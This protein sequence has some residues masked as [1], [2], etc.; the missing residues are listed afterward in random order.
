ML[1][2]I[3]S[4]LLW[5]S[6]VAP[7]CARVS[8][9]RPRQAANDET[10]IMFSDPLLDPNIITT[11]PK[12]TWVEN[13]VAR[14]SDGNF[15]A[16]LLS[17]PQVY[18]LSSTGATKPTLVAEFP[19]NLGALGIVE[20]GEDIFYAVVGNYSVTTGTNTP[21]S[22]SIWEIDLNGWSTHPKRH[23]WSDSNWSDY[24]SKPPSHART[25][26]IASLPTAG[27][28]NGLTILD[29]SS[30]TLLAADSLHGSVW[31]INVHTG[32]VALAINDPTMSPVPSLSGGLSIG[33]NGLSYASSYLYYDNSNT[34]NFYRIPISPS[35]GTPTGAAELLIDQEFS[36]IF[37]DDFTLDS[38][39]NAWL[40]C[41][42]GHVAFF[43][44]VTN[45]EKH[46]ITA[47]AGNST[48]LPHGFTSVKFGITEE[49]KERGSLYVATN[50]GAFFAEDTG[51]RTLEGQLVRYDTKV[52]GL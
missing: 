45:G 6:I 23:D 8:G 11:F 10:P 1:L 4:A 27:L 49:D 32:A 7:V 40:A 16:T 3:S 41:E 22:Y 26:H 15:L 30:G 5:A 13:L 42:W 43:E 9:L 34:V 52:L 37:P 28:L 44:G 19:G 14:S 39:G 36:N 20:L 48:G 18:L 25:K 17:A 21:G 50:G 51:E 2:K 31:S 29:A 35:T 38:Q 33:I 12:G 46:N 24:H 47:V